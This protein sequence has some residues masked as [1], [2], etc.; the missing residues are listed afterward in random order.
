LETKASTPLK[1]PWFP[2]IGKKPFY[3]WVIVAVG[4]IAQLIQGIANQGFTTYLGPLQ[5][6]FGWSR[7]ILAGPRSVTQAETAV[8]GPLEGFMVDR[9]G[10]RIM[11]LIGAFLTGGGL[12]LFG[13]TQSLWT[14]FL[15]N[16][17]ISLGFGFQGLMVLSV[18]L[19]HWFRRRR[20]IANA[21][22]TLG[23]PVAGIVG[24]PAI[25]FIQTS[26]GWRTAAILTGCFIITV[27]IP[28]ALLMRRSPEPYGLNLDGDTR[29]ITTSAGRKDRPEV[30]EE[31]D[32]TLRE[33]LHART[34]WI[35][36][37][38]LALI[39]MTQ[40]AVTTHLFLHLEQGVGLARTTAALVWTVASTTG[41]P[42]R[43][44]GGFMGDRL[45]K[46][47]I[48]ASASAIM[49][50]SI[51]VLGNATSLSMALVYAM[52]YGIGWGIRVP[53]MGA[54]QG[55]YFGRKSQGI[56][57]GWIMLIGLPLTIATPVIVGLMADIQGT[58]RLIFSIIS[59]AGIGGSVLILLATPP[60]PPVRKEVISGAR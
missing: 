9:L 49:A 47:V 2:W 48:L 22:M 30:Q 32:F 29:A 24:V 13:L 15:A 50:L 41:L 31:Y 33:A 14:Y 17:I 58:Y 28:S 51:L 16:I 39:N 52:L 10:P 53:L 35:L 12:I 21:V 6:E 26:M 46:N 18:A 27:G 59:F 57:R 54:L 1:L 38:G 55:D 4:W 44:I 37:F 19:N 5:K 3:G 20:T 25:V 11:V 36:A 23:F 43:L 60:K 42:F 45:P 56:I 40:A 7:A 8:L 34:F